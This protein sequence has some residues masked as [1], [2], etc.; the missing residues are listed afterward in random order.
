M[1][2]VHF[3]Q[4]HIHYTARGREWAIKNGSRSNILVNGC[5]KHML[6]IKQISSQ[7]W[8]IWWS[9]AKEKGPGLRSNT[10]VGMNTKVALN[11][12]FW[13]STTVQLQFSVTAELAGKSLGR[14]SSGLLIRLFI[15]CICIW[16]LEIN[17]T[18]FMQLAHYYPVWDVTY[19]TA[20]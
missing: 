10:S 15:F 9:P 1:Q 7:Q 4:M 16:N 2:T 8:S 11:C 6:H 5:T 3:I 12:F 19:L 14:F 17:V 20:I 13:R 18:N